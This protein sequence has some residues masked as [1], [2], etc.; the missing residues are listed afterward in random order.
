[1]R[2]LVAFLTCFAALAGC[3]G[4]NPSHGSAA[5]QSSSANQL[6]AIAMTELSFNRTG[7]IAYRVPG[8]PTS[9]TG[10]DDCFSLTVPEGT[11]AMNGTLSWTPDEP[12]MMLQF[13]GDGFVHNSDQMDL[14]SPVSV[15]QAD[16]TGNWLVYAGPGVAGGG[17]SYHLEMLVTVVAGTTMEDLSIKDENC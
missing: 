16:P 13:Q 4:T 9:Y 3:A 6:P 2:T 10:D 11:S 17:V 5:G 7:S 15:S 14:S 12:G 8:A 1:M